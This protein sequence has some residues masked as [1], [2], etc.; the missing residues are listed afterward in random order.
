M[1]GADIWVFN[2]VGG[3]VVAL[4]YHGVGDTTPVL[5]TANGG[6]NNLKVIGQKVTSTGSFI[7]F[8]RV[9]NTGDTKN[10]KVIKAGLTSFIWAT[11]PGSPTLTFHGS[12]FGSLRVNLL[13]GVPVSSQGVQG[14]EQLA[15]Y[16]EEEANL[17]EEEGM[18]GE[19]AENGENGEM[20][21]TEIEALEVGEGL[22][23][24]L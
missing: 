2:V 20:A 12:N 13:A 21:I 22:S 24:L 23:L 16:F 1:L 8:T 3:K 7:K 11:E 18:V 5:D 19:N 4:D 9:L 6:K 15:G 14:E 10:D 17:S